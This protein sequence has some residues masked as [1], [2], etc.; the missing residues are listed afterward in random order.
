MVRVARE[1]VADLFAL[2]ETE[3]RRGPLDLA[4][5]YVGL[6]RRI[7]MRYNIRL[8]SEYSAWYCRGCSS[9]WIEGRTVRTRLRGG[10]QVR[11]CLVC[12]RARR[13]PLKPAAGARARD[14]ADSLRAASSPSVALVEGGDG[15]PPDDDDD[16]GSEDA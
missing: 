5:R 7:G 8:P 9:Y 2:A 6:A 3:A 16:D 13:I 12:G 11:T 1:R 15:A 10:R 4:N 14:A